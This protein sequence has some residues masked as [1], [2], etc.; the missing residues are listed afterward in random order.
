MCR[1]QNQVTTKPRHCAMTRHLIPPGDSVTRLDT[2]IDIARM[3]LASQRVRV[4]IVP[5]RVPGTASCA[6]HP[7]LRIARTIPSHSALDTDR[8]G[9]ARLRRG[10]RSQS[11]TNRAGMPCLCGWVCATVACRRESGVR[12]HVDVRARTACPLRGPC[13]ACLGNHGHAGI[14]RRA[15]TPPG[16]GIVSRSRYRHQG[17]GQR[18]ARRRG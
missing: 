1:P 12:G 13:A 17:G 6:D 11:V 14:V 16:S 5:G 9:C 18:P 15:R 4:R 2:Y 3:P 8:Q 10:P 7:V